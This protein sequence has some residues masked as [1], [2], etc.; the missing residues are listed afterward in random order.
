[1]VSLSVSQRTSWAYTCAGLVLS[2]L[3][4]ISVSRVKIVQT[5]H[6]LSILSVRSMAITKINIKCVSDAN[7]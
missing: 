2:G 1:M 7:K 6:A 3:C 4:M 5:L